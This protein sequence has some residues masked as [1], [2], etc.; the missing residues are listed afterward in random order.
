[1]GTSGRQRTASLAIILCG[2]AG[3]YE[4]A[5]GNFPAEKPTEIS[6]KIWKCSLFPMEYQ[7]IFLIIENFL[8]E[9]NIRQDKTKKN[10]A[11][12]V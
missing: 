11:W 2:Q 8:S 12:V 6:S 3:E 7:Q 9:C 4:G 10:T 5:A 1:M